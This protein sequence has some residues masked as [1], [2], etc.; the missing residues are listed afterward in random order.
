MKAVIARIDVRQRRILRRGF[1]QSENGVPA[2]PAMHFRIGSMAIPSLTTI[3]FRLQ[4]E[5][6]LSLDDRLSKWLPAVPRASRVKLRMLTN[7]TAG[8]Y[9]YIQGNQDFLDLLYAN[10]FRVWKPDELLKVAFDRG[11]PCEPGACFRY[12]HASY[13]LLS[14]VISKATRQKT[15]DVMRALIFRPLGLRR[16]GISPLAPMPEP[17]LHA[18][19]SDR[20]L[21]EDSTSWSP[22]WTVGRGTIQ[23]STI[24]D[25]TRMARGVLSG[26][27]LSRSS[28][29]QMIAPLTAGFPGFSADRYYAQGLV[30]GNGWRIQNPNL[31]GYNGIMAFLPDRQMSIA[32][33]GTHSQ[34]SAGDGLSLAGNVFGALTRYLTPAH[35]SPIP[36]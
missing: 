12:S 34:R 35:P 15:A 28:R 32:L 17:T 6:R 5:G 9:D 33:V 19:T 26:S 20:G 27:L 7:S 13:I 22:S 31:N 4:E 30:M 23:N 16:T 24:D 11:F 2:T 25:V 1:G 3:A 21:Y 36:S 18:F 8:Y 10:P 14:Q 29:R